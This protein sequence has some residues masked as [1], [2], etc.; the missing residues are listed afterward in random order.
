MVESKAELPTGDATSNIEVHMLR[1]SLDTLP[2]WAV[3][4]GF[5]LRRGAHSDDWVAIQSAAEPFLQITA[6][7]DHEGSWSAEFEPGGGNLPEHV[8]REDALKSMFFLVEDSSGKAVGTATAWRTSW[9][10][11]Y[12]EMIAAHPTYAGF[13]I[14]A[15]GTKYCRSSWLESSG[16]SLYCCEFA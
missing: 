8:S 6:T 11:H 5:S 12:R 14:A 2:D 9:H 13:D 7:G 1:S 16:T 3:P 10:K 4:Q 15:D